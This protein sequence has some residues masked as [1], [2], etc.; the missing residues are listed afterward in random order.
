MG[1]STRYLVGV[2]VF[3]NMPLN[4]ILWL[5]TGI[6]GDVVRC[7]FSALLVVSFSLLGPCFPPSPG[8]GVMAWGGRVSAGSS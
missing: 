3:Q 6:F 1:Y 5:F 8:G 7:L 2:G 4:G